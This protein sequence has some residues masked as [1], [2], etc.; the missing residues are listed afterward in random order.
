MSNDEV[1]IT[2]IL[3]E[4]IDDALLMLGENGRASIYFHIH[5]KFSLKKEEIPR[6]MNSFSSAIREIF[7]QGAAVIENSILKILCEKLTLDYSYFSKFRFQDAIQIISK[8]LS[9][10]S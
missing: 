10:T 4:I 1:S 2:T 3:P 9:A 6:Q 7:G 8:N 5:R